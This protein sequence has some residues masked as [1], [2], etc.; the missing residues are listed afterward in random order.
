V[1]VIF[2]VAVIEWNTNAVE[3]EGFVVFGILLREEVFEELGV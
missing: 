3:T 2:E 1:H